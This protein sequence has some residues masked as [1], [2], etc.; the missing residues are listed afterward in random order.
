[1]KVI[2]KKIIIAIIIMFI[3]IL[4]GNINCCK[5]RIGDRIVGYDGLIS[6]GK[7]AVGGRVMVVERQSAL[8]QT[9]YAKYNA[10]GTAQSKTVT[11]LI[12]LSFQ[13]RWNE[14]NNRITAKEVQ[15]IR[16][17]LGITVS[18]T[19]TEQN[20]TDILN[21]IVSTDDMYLVQ[22]S[23]T[24]NG[25]GSKTEMY[26][27][28][29]DAT[30]LSSDYEIKRFIN[31]EGDTL[32]DRY[33]GD[34]NAILAYIL[35]E[36]RADG[37]GF[38]A[39]IRQY[40]VR[41]YFN[42]W[43]DT[44]GSK[45]GVGGEWKWDT[46]NDKYYE[47]ADGKVWVEKGKKLMEN[48]T[49]ATKTMTPTIDSSESKVSID[50]NEVPVT[51][52]FNGD[53]SLVSA[54]GI[55]GRIIRESDLNFK[56]NGRNVS[57]NNIESG[58]TFY[59]TPKDSSKRIRKIS[60]K[61]TKKVPCANIWLAETVGWI[62]GWQLCDA[63]GHAKTDSQRFMV[64]E[65]YKTNVSSPTIS[66][67]VDYIGKITVNKINS[68]TNQIISNYETKF[69][70]ATTEGYLKGKR[71]SY[72]YNNSANNA[73]E[74]T[75]SKGILVLDGLKVGQY[76]IEEID[77]P[78]G[79]LLSTT[80]ENVTISETNLKPSAINFKNTPAGSITIRKKDTQT[81]N[82]ITPETKFKIKTE[83][84]WLSGKNGLYTYNNSE[85]NGEIYS[86]DNGI[87]KIECLLFGKY[88]VHEVEAPQ[89]YILSVQTTTSMDFDINENH[90]KFEVDFTNLRKGSITIYKTDEDTNQNIEGAG[91]K[92]QTSNGWLQG[93]KAPYTYNASY[94]NATIYKVNSSEYTNTDNV[95]YPISS[96]D[97]G[98]KIDG[99][100]DG[101]YHIYEVEPPTGYLLK[102]QE[103]YDAS[104]G[105]VD[106]NKVITISSNSQVYD[107]KTTITNVKK[108]SIEG[109]VWEDTPETKESGLYNSLYD[110][111]REAKIEGVAVRL[112]KKGDT[113]PIG[114][115]TTDENGKYLFD[116]LIKLSELENYYIEFNYNGLESLKT[117]YKD[118]AGNEHKY[119]K[120]IPVE[121]KATETNGSKAI[122]NAV[123]EKDE[124]LSGIA[125]TYLGSTAIDTYG[126]M[127]CGTFDEPNL[128]VSNINL[129]IKEI[130]DANYTLDENI[131]YVRIVMKGYT[132]TYKYG[133]EGNTSSVGAPKVNFQKKGTIS[134]YT[135]NIYPSDI[136]YEAK[137]GREELKV[138]VGYRIDITNT[139]NIKIDELY[140]EKTLHIK[141]LTD[142]FD[143]DRYTLH[144][145]N[146]NVDGNV[147]T[148]KDAYLEDIK[149]TGIGLD[150]PTATKRIEFQVNRSA[151]L[152]ILDKI[153]NPN[154]IIE[155][156]PTKV[157]T[158]GYHKYERY[159]YGWSYNIKSRNKQTHITADDVEEAD[160]PYLIFKLGPERVISGKVFK[161]KVITN[162]GE[163]LGNGEYDNGEKGVADVNVE[164]LDLNET[165]TDVTKLSVSNVYGVEGYG[166]NLSKLA[167]V[168]TK[169]DGSYSL[170]G[171]VPGFYY[172]RFVYGNG[173]YKITDL[174][175]NLI[176][177]NVESKIDNNKIEAKKY[178]STIVT[179]E[180]AKNALLGGEGVE[181]YKKIDNKKFF[182]VAIDNLEQRKA[183]NEGT[184]T[185]MMA[186]IAKVSI[187]V[188][189]TDEKEAE[190]KQSAKLDGQGNKIV[191]AVNELEFP[192]KEEF[193]GISFG[194]IEVPRQELEIKKLIT[195]V[196]LEN[197]QGNVL[198]NGNPENTPSYGV[199]AL[200]DL[201]NV[202]NGGSTYVRAEMQEANLYGTNLELTYEVS[203]TNKSD[204]NYYN[205]E[206]YW[207]G[208]KNSKKEITLE[209][210]NVR[211]YLDQS[212]TY[213]EDKSDKDRINPKGT[214]T[215][216]VD[217]ESIKA[218]DMELNGWKKLYTNKNKSRNVENT[219]DKVKI[220]AGRILSNNDADMEI[221]SRAEIK[222]VNRTP[223]PSDPDLPT[224]EAEVKEQIRIAPKEVHT[225]GMVKAIFTIMPPT[226]ENREIITIYAIAGII[227]L[228]VLSI[229]I[230]IIKKKI[231]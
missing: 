117:T 165:E 92:I 116:S 26:C 167:Q 81:G 190:V 93:T 82:L 52:T 85:N 136:S 214:T 98:L 60:F 17:Y 183:V 43:I 120:Y 29:H 223:D 112:M 179:N 144:D 22:K 122:M 127:K 163:V 66:I 67:D 18:T 95:I 102:H 208:Q 42:T 108:I 9:V 30:I 185:S 51:L 216:K 154:G 65:R 110:S 181:W 213:I 111:T 175:G 146:W 230:L 50:S 212:L 220:V 201:D 109:Y 205:N 142:T 152:S 143:K 228:I 32:N 48:A 145:D 123:A 78:K 79:Y 172:L 36:E 200:N 16:D 12:K 103:G 75:T 64:V 53:L 115:T 137:N 130:P 180:I 126:L 195:N 186:G 129:G 55:D 162:N 31:I 19:L 14:L 34:A 207:Y 27:V 56:Q 96:T 221:V 225:N 231:I 119:N 24:S 10:S 114:E 1:M 105:Y 59:I 107:I 184:L 37:Y 217:N 182:S 47:T 202:A 8:S 149:N 141:S 135:A 80:T 58:T 73:G 147:A 160:A 156:Y 173:T 89:G 97:K 124:D 211:D 168:K 87:F 113:T 33:S 215:I 174:A 7:N 131:D 104:K 139:T 100:D 70:I 155:E 3:T 198:Y 187:T 101:A 49:K 118:L 209:P 134:G 39:S 188:E 106:T 125:T 72:S 153:T 94:E 192:N 219:T 13:T 158:I 77:P 197:S 74:Y 83:E 5:A 203:I 2:T 177:T 196:K 161:D 121:L 193:K 61:T 148:I 166:E 35:N 164:L 176:D 90:W 6:E 76:T 189:N 178:K 170:N 40:A 194:I 86:T 151:I 11:D 15:D 91:F 88:T 210:T 191:Q 25:W 57:I 157:T 71:G 224:K 132:Y 68:Y 84:G 28:Q 99:L 227:V 63:N 128:M 229:G 222:E 206:Y 159:D 23:N 46:T 41:H 44:F 171:I 20:K 169:A 45:T 226:G 218:Q 133:L 138:Y 150:K 4:F 54:I 38:Y 62:R 204:I 199:V 69:R 21:K 140:E